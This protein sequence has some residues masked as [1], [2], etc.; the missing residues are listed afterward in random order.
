MEENVKKIL[1]WTAG[2]FGMLF[3]LAGF[4][5]FFV[6][7][8]LGNLMASF[9]NFDEIVGS[10]LSNFI[11]DNRED[12]RGFVELQT[13]QMMG[14]E[15]DEILK[16]DTMTYLCQTPNVVNVKGDNGGYDPAAQSFQDMLKEVC[17]N[18]LTIL[19]D[20]EIRAIVID[21]LV[22]QNIENVLKTVQNTE[23][24]AALLEQS[25]GTYNTAKPFI[26]GIAIFLYL[27]GGFLTF[28][29]VS[30]NWKRGTYSITLSTSLKLLTAGT[31]FWFISTMTADSIVKIIET[32]TP[33]FQEQMATNAPPLIIKLSA[34]VIL[35]LL[36]SA[37]NPLISVAFYAAIPFVIAVGILIYLKIQGKK[38]L[39]AEEKAIKE[40]VA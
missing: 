30:F 16:K 1:R 37:T 14:P 28:V 12:V 29:S 5:L 38:K 23:E 36:R 24:V 13:L 2:I 33:T 18:D 6:G 31:A 32:M 10:S 3:M 27:L 21:T 19:T 26:F 40:E 20:S 15:F 7:L 8:I 34:A 4:L 25:K 39:K 17:K 35:D 11:D 22:D 9:D